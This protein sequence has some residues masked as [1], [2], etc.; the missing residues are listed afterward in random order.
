MVGVISLV[1]YGR[2]ISETQGTGILSTKGVAPSPE[3]FPL[4]AKL[5]TALL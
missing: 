5:V 3:H 2:I 4:V 1:Y